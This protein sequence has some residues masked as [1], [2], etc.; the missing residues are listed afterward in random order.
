[1]KT[2]K[3]VQ[4]LTSRSIPHITRVGAMFALAGLAMMAVSVL[5][6]RPLAVILAMSMGHALGAIAV[7][8]YVLA[9]ILD[10]AQKAPPPEAGA[11]ASA[12]QAALGSSASEPPAAGGDERNG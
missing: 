3:M 12:P 6:P 8:C 9:V 4:S 7:L 5:Y 11:P 2:A 1:M 10:V